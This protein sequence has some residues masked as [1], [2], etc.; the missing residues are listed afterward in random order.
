MITNETKMITA[1]VITL[2]EIRR[3]EIRR[4]YIL[5]PLGSK[6]ANSLGMD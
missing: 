1:E 3:E 5:D 4:E 6:V 2:E